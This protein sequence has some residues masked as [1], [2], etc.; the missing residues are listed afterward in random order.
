[1]AEIIDVPD[2]VLAP[3]SVSVADKP[4]PKVIRSVDDAVQKALPVE[5]SVAL[6]GLHEFLN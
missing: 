5:M 4:D 1:M 3:A 6:S 2:I